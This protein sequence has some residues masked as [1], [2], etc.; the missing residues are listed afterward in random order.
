[1]IELSIYP[2]RTVVD[3]QFEPNSIMIEEDG[4]M[5]ELQTPLTKQLIDRWLD[6]YAR[7]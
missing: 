7:Y 4:V 1:M 5:Q 6:A 2:D 3:W